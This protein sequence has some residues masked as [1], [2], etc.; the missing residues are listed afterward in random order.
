MDS[1]IL[2]PIVSTA[3]GKVRG[4]LRE[5]IY[6]DT[7]Y[8]FDG[9]PYAKPPLG[10]LR[11]KS[12][13][14]VEPWHGVRDCTICPPMCIQSNYY[15]GVI[16]GIE[17][18]LYLNVFTK[19]LRSA[20]PLPVLAYLLGGR[21]AIGDASRNSWGP[22]YLMMKDVVYITIGFRLG[23]LGFLSFPE[24]ELQVPGNAGLKD[25]VMALQW[26]KKNCQY[27]NGDPDNITLFGHSSGS[28]TAQMLMYVPQCENL[29]HKV[30]LIS[31][32][33][34]HLRRIP[35]LEYRFAKHLGYKGQENNHDILAYLS[36]LPAERLCDLKILTPVEQKQGHQSV[37]SPTLENE[38]APDAIL[39]KDLLDLYANK[40]SWCHSIPLVLGGSSF[41]GLMNY[42]YFTKEPEL[43]ETLRK[44]PEYLLPYE[45]REKY[46]M[47]TQQQLAKKL[48][49]L[50]LGEKELDIE[51]S[52]DLMDL[53]TVRL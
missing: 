23:A 17:D 51:Q 19:K 44:H 34:M 42:K 47:L 22:D 50:H 38:H 25:I 24:P 18:C 1:Q 43:Y 52:F 32:M 53:T 12:P 28:A 21:F 29:F 4:Q 8:S 5:G 11:F 30:I 7:Y 49:R 14:P 31:G 35:Q 41:E 10:K 3:S 27:F 40:Q 48:I 33:Q 15:T 9:I 46:D 26:I 37:F 39:T 45:V 2:E 13:Q 36:A 16:D 20:K 6:G